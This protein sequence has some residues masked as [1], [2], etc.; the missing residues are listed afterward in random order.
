MAYASAFEFVMLVPR[1]PDRHIYIYIYERILQ[2]ISTSIHST[3]TSVFADQTTYVHMS[4]TSKLDQPSP[5]TT[6]AQ[7]PVAAMWMPSP[8]KSTAENQ[9]EEERRRMRIMQLLLANEPGWIAI[10]GRLRLATDRR[11]CALALHAG[12]W[13]T[14]R[15]YIVWGRRH[16][17]DPVQRE[18]SD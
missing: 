13:N 10:Q 5:W 2:Y 9:R 7:D 12:N 15:S 6:A 1:R 17:D 4:G 11:A 8:A 18:D 3:T 16:P 14:A